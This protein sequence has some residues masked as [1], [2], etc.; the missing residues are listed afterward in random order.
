M[1]SPINTP[2]IYQN[3]FMALN[4]FSGIHLNSYMTDT[5]AVKGPAYKSN[6]SGPN[7][8]VQQKLITPP[9]IAAT[10]AFNAT[11]QVVTIHIGS[12]QTPGS[13]GAPTIMLIDPTTLDTLY[14]VVLPARPDNTT[15]KISFAGGYFYL[16]Q[17]SNVVCVVTSQKPKLIQ[18]IQI[19]S[20]TNNKIALL[21]TIDLSS[22]INDPRIS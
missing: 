18:Q 8:S 6:P 4:G 7:P 16:D 20:T 9:G 12:S 3:P 13:G 10:M 11:G 21:Q 5:G 19:Y 17:N 1:P 14:T 2:P 15:G 22:A